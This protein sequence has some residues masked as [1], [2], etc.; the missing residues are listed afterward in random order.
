MNTIFMVLITLIG[1]M[2]FILYPVMRW[3]WPFS[4]APLFGISTIIAILYIFGLFNSL[5]FG[6]Y[7][8]FAGSIILTFLSAYLSRKEYKQALAQLFSPSLLIFFLL[9][10]L[11]AY[12]SRSWMLQEWDEYSHWGIFAKAMYFENKFP[13]QVDFVI[14][15]PH[16]P[17]G[18]TIFQYFVTKLAGYSEKALFFSQNIV[19]LSAIVAI[20]NNITWK[21]SFLAIGMVFFCYWS[22]YFWG[23]RV[24]T[25]YMDGLLG[26]VFGATIAA[27]C[28]D[29]KRDWSALIKV[30]P[31]LFVL[32]LIKQL[33]IIFALIIAGIIVFDQIVFKSDWSGGI[34]SFLNKAGFKKSSKLIGLLALPFL[35][36][37]SWMLFLRFWGVDEYLHRVQVSTLLNSF[38]A[39]A[40]DVQRGVV[41]NFMGAYQNLKIGY[42]PYGAMGIV[43]VFSTLILIYSFT[44]ENNAKKSYKEWIYFQL[45][46]LFG[47]V[48][49]SVILFTYFIIANDPQLQSYTRYL[50]TYC[51]GWSYV[52]LGMYYMEL[53]DGTI[54]NI[55][56][57]RKH[58]L[59][60]ASVF[61]I[62][63]VL[64]LTP[65]TSIFTPPVKF[66]PR[67]LIDN[68]IEKF[69]PH[70]EENSRVW[71]IWQ[72]TNGLE[73]HIT[74]YL[75][76]PR[77]VNGFNQSYKWSMGE[78]YY[79]GDIWTYNITQMAW[80]TEIDKM[81]Y[82]YILIGSADDKFWQMYGELFC[83][84]QKS[85]QPQLFKVESNC[86]TAIN[87]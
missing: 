59:V 21:K 52:I 43:I 70:M 87:P 17:P 82:D 25:I 47:F 2:G 20:L 4:S 78:P 33:G 81:H 26:V 68:R 37:Y 23:Y 31:V 42:A 12:L 41:N 67:L 15:W 66:A 65:L 22:I 79:E 86:F 10:A 11:L 27:Y 85:K 13:A 45:L 39:S 28:G 19:I 54:D 58:I 56:N 64:A 35:S 84:E 24:N 40:T 8:V 57:Y 73:F 51:L 9:F 83:G 1:I 44:A 48:F 3:K 76:A 34:K 77:M 75:I 46:I 55:Q 71:I 29:K 16:Y 62:A 61:I 72:N 5:L 32:P 50:G 80:R 14:V 36:S 69:I 74:R 63:I 7:F 53:K 30:A 49:Y 60:I 38:S 6:F 18:I